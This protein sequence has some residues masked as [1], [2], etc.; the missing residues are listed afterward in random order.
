MQVP[1]RYHILHQIRIVDSLSAYDDDRVVHDAN[2]MQYMVPLGYLHRSLFQMDLAEL[3]YLGELRT[4]P[5]GH[6]SYRRVAYDMVRQGKERLPGLMQWCRAIA[7][8][9]IGL[10]T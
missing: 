2:L 6:I 4:Q 8:E 10:H 1:E 7:P 9:S 3:Y 5:Q